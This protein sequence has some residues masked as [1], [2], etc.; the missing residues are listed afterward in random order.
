MAVTRSRKQKAACETM[1]ESVIRLDKQINGN[2]Q[3]GIRQ[4]LRALADEAHGFFT[5]S[6]TGKKTE[7]EFHNTRDE[8]IKK[9]LALAAK[10]TNSWMLLITALSFIAM[11]FSIFHSH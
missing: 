4:E 11:V 7:M 2:G 9:A 6:K 5:E 8:E 3:P 10:H 1:C